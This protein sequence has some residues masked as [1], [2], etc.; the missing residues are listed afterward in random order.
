MRL[1]RKMFGSDVG[2]FEKL[3]RAGVLVGIVWYA[4]VLIMKSAVRLAAALA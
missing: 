4:S 3:L 2:W 1:L